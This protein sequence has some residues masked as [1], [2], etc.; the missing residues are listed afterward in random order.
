MNT[1]ITQLTHPSSSSLGSTTK[2]DNYGNRPNGVRHRP[3]ETNHLL[4]N[5]RPTSSRKKVFASWVIFE[6]MAAVDRREYGYG[7]LP[8]LASR[9]DKQ[10]PNTRNSTMKEIRGPHIPLVTCGRDIIVIRKVGSGPR[11]KFLRSLRNHEA[12]QRGLHSNP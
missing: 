5:G 11:N 7:I 8:R 10:T 6:E 1:F 3:Q 9:N 2:F 12:P 4:A